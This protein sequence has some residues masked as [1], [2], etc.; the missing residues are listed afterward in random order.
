M[1]AE[2]SRRQVTE[3]SKRMLYDRLT[4]GTSGNISKIDEESGLIAITPSGVEYDILT[5]E[6]ITLVDQSGEV[7]EG[8]FEPSTELLMHLHIYRNRPDVRG[9]VHTH[10]M[11]AMTLSVL[12]REIP[13]MHYMVLALGGPVPL[14][15]YAVFGS[16][17]L[18]ENVVRALG[19]NNKAVLL[20]NHGAVTVGGSLEE[21]Y[22]NALLLEHMA[23]LYWRTLV[24]EEPRLLTK[25]EIEEATAKLADYGVARLRTSS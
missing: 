1:R 8:A 3:F 6:M 11:Y 16:Q 20:S 18:A 4:S 9:I 21:A 15:E 2:E 14:A 12:R 13:V 10:S 7:V 19:T 25:T 17:Q 22:R 24:V 5:P 23:E